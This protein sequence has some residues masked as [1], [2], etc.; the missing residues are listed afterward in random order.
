MKENRVRDKME[1]L[2]WVAISMASSFKV[3]SVGTFRIRY[4]VRKEY[5]NCCL[6]R[7]ASKNRKFSDS[8]SGRN[9]VCFD[10]N[11]CV[12]KNFKFTNFLLGGNSKT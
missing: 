9:R 1:K 6:N 4:F 12:L 10:Q 2:L 11:G 3:K 8:L 5:V 7:M